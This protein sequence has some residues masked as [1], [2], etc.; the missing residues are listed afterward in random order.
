MLM[1]FTL[2][3]NSFKHALTLYEPLR[4]TVRCE[5][6]RKED[7]TGIRIV[8]EDSGDGFSQEVLDMIR[9]ENPPAFTKEH[10]GLNNVRYTL[11][12]TYH[13]SNLLQLRNREGGGA[14]VELWIPEEEN[15]ETADM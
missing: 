10:L 3:E 13:R 6:I 12:L 7:F 9:S 2:V 5:R 14:H 1:L 15:H 11:N 4:I 8:E